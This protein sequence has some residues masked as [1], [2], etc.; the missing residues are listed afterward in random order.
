MFALC[1]SGRKKGGLGGGHGG[2]GGGHKG[3]HKGGMMGMMMMGLG[4]KMAALVPLIIGKL[5]LMASKALI[6]SKIAL[7]LALILALKK[8]LA[9]KQGH[10][11][12]EVEHHD[13]HG[14]GW[15]RRAIDQT[16]AHDQAYSAHVKN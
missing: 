5:F 6:I 9:S 11:H 3:G 2:G 4:M 7:V 1:S 16:S 10:S 12:H 14:Q 13:H 8:I 15:D